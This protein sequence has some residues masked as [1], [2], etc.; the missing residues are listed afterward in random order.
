MSLASNITLTPTAGNYI[1]FSCR[2]SASNVDVGWKFAS[3]GSFTDYI[4]LND[5]ALRV[6]GSNSTV[7]EYTDGYTKPAVNTDFILR[8]ELTSDNSWQ[9]FLN[10]VSLG[11]KTLTNNL[12]I[13]ELLSVNGTGTD[14][15]FI[16]D[17]HYVELCSDGTG[18]ATNRWENTTGTGTTWVDQIGTNNAAQVGTWPADNSEWVLIGP[19]VDYTAR[20]ASTATITHTLTA[21]GLTS[22]TLDGQAVTIASQSG[23]TADITFTDTITTSGVYDLV[24]GDGV[25]NQTLKVQYNVIGLTTNTIQKEG[26][27]IG[28][29]TD[30]EIDILD[31][32]GAT[33]LDTLTGLTTDAAGDTG[34]AIVAAGAVD[35]AVRVSGYSEAAGIGFAYKTTLGLL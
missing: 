28:A 19:A 8:L 16:G 24:L 15:S 12:I 20:K 34:T 1:E 18:I 4:E 2:A 23:Q 30:L 5:T 27:S 33:V 29:R 3:D 22:A 9:M 11:I 25:G 6:R 26:A 10:G 21:A 7:L 31:A 14:N 35:D 13:S 17:M 32:T